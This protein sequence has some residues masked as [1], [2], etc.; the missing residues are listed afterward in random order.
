[1]I[2][3]G[4]RQ[5]DIA[6]YFAVNGGRIGETSTGENFAAVPAAT[7]NLPPSAPY[8]V[9]SGSRRADADAVLAHLNKSGAPGSII[10]AQRRIVDGMEASFAARQ[11][12]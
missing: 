3:R 1:M 11:G 2:A 5:H 8:L 12:K 4:D 7:T 9:L 6:A 10:A